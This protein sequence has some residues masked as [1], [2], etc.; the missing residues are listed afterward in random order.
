MIRDFG[1]KIAA[2]LFQKGK[3]KGLPRDLWK[4]AVYLLDI[5]EAVDSLEVLKSRGFPPNL[6][7]HPL[8]GSRK[9]EFA[10]DINKV[11]GWRITFRFEGKE[12][13]DVKVEDYH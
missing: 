1:N 3:S 13:F 12:F 5:M 4:R 2:D 6:R 9:G 7:L 10:I 8:K 11:S